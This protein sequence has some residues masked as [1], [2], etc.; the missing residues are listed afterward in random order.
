MW[1]WTLTRAWTG[2]WFSTVI[3][4]AMSMVRVPPIMALLVARLRSSRSTLIWSSTPSCSSNSS[5][6]ATV[7]SDV[8][9]T[10]PGP[11]NT[12]AGPGSSSSEE[13]FVTVA[14]A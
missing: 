4:Y 8:S 1:S 12:R 11:W 14:R 13:V 3:S 7:S 5:P 9:P 2:R 10:N 6:A